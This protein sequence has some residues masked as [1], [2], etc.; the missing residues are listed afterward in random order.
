M[1]QFKKQEIAMYTTT[2][3]GLITFISISSNPV[4][5]IKILASMAAVMGC[6]VLLYKGILKILNCIY[7]EANEKRN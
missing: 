4:L 3:I 1:N 6:F 2:G 7:P 5:Y